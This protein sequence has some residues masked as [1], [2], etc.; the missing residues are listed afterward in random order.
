MYFPAFSA[1]SP[2]FSSRRLLRISA[3]GAALAAALLCFTS[4]A[5]ADSVVVSYTLASLSA[6]SYQYTY[7][8]SGSLSAKDDLA[9]L[10]PIG[11]VSSLSNAAGSGSDFSTFAL[12]PDSGLPADGEFDI[13]ALNANP[14]LS[15]IFTVNFLYTGSGVPS[16]QAF[17]LYDGDFNV[18]Q[19]GTTQAAVIASSVTPEPASLSL[20]ATGVAALFATW[21]KRSR[22]A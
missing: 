21:C 16:A 18:L 6:S 5:R 14:D 15:S 2:L 11:S 4:S 12:Q 20:L 7:T 10:F 19:T 3:L 13:L 22:L 9:I 17:T 1:A 8:L